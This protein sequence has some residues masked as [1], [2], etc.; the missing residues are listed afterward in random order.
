MNKKNIFSVLT[1]AVLIGA[2]ALT[3]TSCEDTLDKP[4][5]T[6]DG[7]DFV[8]EDLNKAELFVKGLYRG[9][10][11][12][13]LWRPFIDPTITA[14][15]EEDLVGGR[16]RSAN[17]AY[18]PILPA[19]ATSVYN[20]SLKTIESCNIAIA[21]LE[22]MAESAKRDALLA[23]AIFIRA[24]AYNELIRFYGDV[25]A[26]FVPMETLDPEADETW[27]PRRSDRDA[28]YDRIIGEMQQYVDKLP[29][30][31][32]AGYGSAPERLTRQAAK[33][34]LAR[35][36]LYAGGYSLRWNT[37]TN[38]PSTL[39]MARRDDE[40]RVREL[41]TIAN[42]QLEDIFAKNENQLIKNGT[43]G[44]SAYQTLFFNYCQR[45]FGV[46]SQEF[47]WQ[48]AALGKSTNSDFGNW[49]AN[50]SAYGGSYGKCRALQVKLPTYYLSFDA[51]DTRR[52]VT[53]C[54]FANTFYTS[55]TDDNFD[56]VMCATT[57]SSILGGKFRVQWCQ[58]PFAAADRNI[59]VPMLR[60]AD[61]L[62]MYAE[63]Q[64]Y[65]NGPNAAAIA[66]VKEVR[67][68]AGI[69][70][71]PIASGSREEF[72]ETIMQ[73]R[74]WELADELLIRGDLIRTNLISK[75]I[76]QAQQDI[77]DLSDKTGKYANVAPI[78]LVRLEM[79][80][81]AFGDNALTVPF[82]EITDPAEIAKLNPTPKVTTKAQRDAFNQ[83]VNDVL[84][85][86]GITDGKTW[87]AVKMFQNW[88]SSYNKNARRCA[89]YSAAAV[90]NLNIG[91]SIFLK[92][93]GREENGGTYPDW[94]AGEHGIYYGFQ[95][96]K[97]ELCPFAAKSAGHPLIDNP[98]LTQHPAY[99]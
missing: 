19:T 68:R 52:D 74:K 51:N 81:G 92:N 43:D 9:L 7:L 41:Y 10:V 13:E 47:M 62:L 70:S 59:D 91:Q 23:E 73:E 69:G 36:C 67:D 90:T 31:S 63:T 17:F 80:T 54:N 30:F 86:H 79:S 55:N 33:G 96:N 98:N 95:E 21:R 37:E 93:T 39:H 35:I 1:A 12:T 53:C 14:S 88:S 42:T 83:I 16:P 56:A 75:H 34:I 38:D 15:C 46:S 6:S 3:L 32:E 20:Q 89:G 87:Y 99:K 8:F 49:N 24:F 71:M 2:P 22:G 40:A 5:Y 94:V 50:P 27:H 97:T 78:R 72:L 29:W 66:A 11:Y 82:V 85:A 26:Q 25:P 58:E 77:K 76:R 48:I 84:A 18:D 4:S 65:L 61:I 28:I 45:N 44:M 64:N 57:F 60:Y